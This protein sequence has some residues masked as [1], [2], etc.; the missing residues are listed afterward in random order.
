MALDPQLLRSSFELV[1]DRRPDVTA[2]FY[3]ELFTRHP[4]ARA[5]FGR[6]SR[7]EQ[8]AML[9]AALSAVL[10]HLEDGQWLESALTELGRKHSEYGVI[11]E[12]YGWVGEAL[13]ATFAKVAGTDWSPEC[14]QAWTAAYGAISS[15]MLSG[16]PA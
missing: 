7:Q 1:I 11:E 6:N 15:T 10:D 2:L 4:E 8:E 9:A 5:L 12:H 3:D 16:A 13:L 14:E